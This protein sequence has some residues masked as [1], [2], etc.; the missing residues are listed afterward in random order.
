MPNQLS[1][2][3]SLFWLPLC[4]CASVVSP[5]FCQEWTHWR[6]PL[7]TGFSPEKNLP[8]EW[9][10]RA[11]GKNNLIWKQPYG[12]RS[13]PLVMNG[14]VYI[15]GADNEPLSVPTTE[16]KKKIGERVTCFDTAK[17]T[18]IWEHTFNVFHTDIVANRLGWAPLAGDAANK[19]LYVHSTGGFLFCFDSESGKILWERQLTEEFGRTTGYGGRV[20]GGPIFDSGLVIVGI[21]NSSWGNHG[22]GTNR[23]YAFDGKTGEAQW[24]ATVPGEFHRNTY[25]SNPV[26]AVIGGQRL[27]ISGGAD[28]ALTAY[29]VRTGKP[30]WT[31]MCCSGV[32]NPAPVVDGNFVY[33]CHGEENPEGASAGLGRVVCVDASKIVA[34]KG[35]GIGKPT[36]VWEYK[37]GIRFGLASPAIAG[38][39]LYIPDDA[40]KLYCFDAK[41]GKQLWKYNYGTVSRGAPV[42]AD[43]KIYIAE[44][45]FK[46]HIIRLKED[47]SEPD[48]SETN[49]VTFRNKQGATGFVESN[50]T[51]SI[52]NG[53][54]YLATRDEIY[55]I[56]KAN[57]QGT[58][59]KL[60][61][62]PKEEDGDA[63]PTKGYLHVT[64]AEATVAPGGKATFTV[65]W[66]TD[67]GVPAKTFVKVE[68]EPFGV[69]WSLPTPPIPKG[70][71]MAPPPLK[72]E[73]GK[74]GGIDIEVTVDPKMPSQ[75]GYVEAGVG[76][77]LK[78]QARVRVIPQIPYTQDFEKTPVGAV[79]GGWVNT[80]GKYRVVELKEANGMAKVLMKV[81]T[82]ASPPVAGA[83]A[84]I[85]APKST[86]Y[87]IEAD[88]KGVAARGTLPD[89]GVCANRYIL[90]LDGK[91]DNGKREVRIT[92]W[93]ALPTP[94]PAGRVAVE[95]E[96]TWKENVWYRVKLSVEVGDKEATVRGKIWERDQKEPEKWTLEMK[97]PRPNREGTAALYGKISNASETEAASEAYFDNVKI[98]PNQKVSRIEPANSRTIV[99]GGPLQR[100]FARCSFALASRRCVLTCQ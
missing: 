1:L 18:K 79:P 23:L 26:V 88:L 8:D 67:K 69:L 54:V 100:L 21:I 74:N 33:I 42:I 73:L 51:P 44:T 7:Q 72:A 77:L 15:T 85:T 3:K 6:G 29:H 2:R 66:Y 16:E 97:D 58:A 90:I 65:R 37:R 22:I 76:P 48:E 68:G 84:Y 50:C 78:A 10:P 53:K 89:L 95:T 11:V 43:D 14:R 94:L 91:T 25:Y 34:G 19:R 41:N 61:A 17:G 56:G 83:L 59:A 35:P 62:S 40:A 60:P 5:A 98:G 20:G 4:L 49:T 87:T 92:T 81:N 13:T 46:F 30:V 96:Y 99:S 47:G 57:W 86:G 70:A 82:N 45:N 9:D 27:L 64:P 39:K 55:C 63:S 24:I 36:V 38:G 71:T 93:E 80:Q 52:V 31:Y 32:I 28:G 12:C 75:Q